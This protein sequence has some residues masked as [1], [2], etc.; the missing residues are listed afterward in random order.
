MMLPD[1]PTPVKLKT[2]TSD[3]VPFAMFGTG[4]DP[5]DVTVFTERS[6]RSGSML[7]KKGSDLMR[8]FLRPDW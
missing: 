7:G 4:I 6:A 8:I 5:D 2:H 1:H 3:P